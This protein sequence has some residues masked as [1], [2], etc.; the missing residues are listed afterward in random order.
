M[1]NGPSPFR[2]KYDPESVECIVA[3][4]C[5]NDF[6]KEGPT[7]IQTGIA[8]APIYIRQCLFR[9]LLYSRSL[10]RCPHEFA[11]GRLNVG[12]V[13]RNTKPTNLFQEMETAALTWKDV[14]CKLQGKAPCTCSV[15]AVRLLGQTVK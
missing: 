11:H 13:C 5:G 4:P 9:E 15:D 6:F 12:S 8:C 14:A 3:R 10:M 7:F 2:Q 1:Q